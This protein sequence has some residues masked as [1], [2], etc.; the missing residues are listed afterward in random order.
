MTLVAKFQANCWFFFLK[1][2]I[3]QEVLP[4]LVTCPSVDPFLDIY[5][6]VTTMITKDTRYDNDQHT[7][8]WI[9]RPTTPDI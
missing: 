8:Y 1:P 2:L 3:N 5:D 4:V 6:F 9:I 7:R